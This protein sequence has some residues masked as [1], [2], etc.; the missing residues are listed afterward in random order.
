METNY[1]NSVENEQHIDGYS[2]STKDTTLHYAQVQ[3][4][5]TGD[6]AT[7]PAPVPKELLAPTLMYL[8]VPSRKEPCS[9]QDSSL[10]CVHEGSCT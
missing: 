6:T 1:T 8:H 10:L 2:E 3:R 9:Y 5:L 4:D 7:P